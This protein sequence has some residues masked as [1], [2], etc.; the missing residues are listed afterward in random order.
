MKTALRKHLPQLIL[1]VAATWLLVQLAVGAG[2]FFKHIW[3]AIRFPFALDYG[4]GPLLDQ[5]IHL[6]HLGNIYRRDVAT[7][8]YTIS[9]YPPVFLLVQVPLAWLFGPA[10]WYGRAINLLSLIA[11]TISIGLIIYTTTDDLI[12]AIVAGLTLLPFPFIVHWSAFNRIDSLALGI[13]C[14]GLYAVVRWG[15]TRRGLI[16]GAALLTA[17]VYTRQSY[18]LAAPLAA[19]MWLLRPGDDALPR[20]RAFELA[21]WVAGMGLGVFL[22]LN[23]ITWGGFYFNIVAAN[24]NPFYWHTVREYAGEVWKNIPYLLVAGALFLLAGLLFA[25]ARLL[26][27]PARLWSGKKLAPRSWWVVAPYLVGA[28]ASAITIGKSGSNVNYLFEFCAALSLV[29]GAWIA[30]PKRWPLLQ[31]ALMLA[32]VPQVAGIARWTREGRFTWIMGKIAERDEI[33]QMT[34]LAHAAD[35]PVLADEY[36]ALVPLAGKPLYFQPFELKQLYL[37]GTW[38]E[39]AFLQ[40]IQDQKFPLLLIYDPPWWNSQKER[41]TPQQLFYISL[42]YEESD[43]LANTII[44]RPKSFVLGD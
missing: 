36:M 1:V 9:N 27:A 3:A 35:G 13:S 20:R 42:Y 40:D 8:P 28:T 17:S 41:W 37:A 38:D 10:L 25:P 44:Y 21:A 39:S 31:A 4:E 6:A 43:R 2:L 26:F 18:A 24:V 11:A 23:L 22:L 29:V 15:H 12:A 30:W 33:A 5:T 34:E 16:W 32:L 19:F 14:A 7:P